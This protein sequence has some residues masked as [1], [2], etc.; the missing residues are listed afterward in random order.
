MKRLLLIILE[1]S[2]FRHTVGLLRGI[3][4]VSIGHGTKQKK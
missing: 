3:K 1:S 4:V 2:I